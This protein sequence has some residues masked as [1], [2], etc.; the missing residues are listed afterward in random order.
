MNN[1]QLLHGKRA[2]VFGAGGS[3]G[4]AVAR[5]FAAEGAEV[6]LCGRHSKGLEDVM[7]SITDAGG[8]ARTVVVDAL[9]EVAVQKCV[10]EI[11]RTAGSIDIEFNAVAPRVEEYGGGKPAVDVTVGE[12]MVAVTTMLK[13]PIITALAA[14]RHI[15]KQRSGV[16]IGVTG[17]TARGHIVGG[18]AI[19]AAFG[20]LETFMENLAFEIG[21]QGVRALC[22][23]VTANVDSNAIHNVARAMNVTDGQIATML[24][25][26]NFLKTPMKLED[27]AKA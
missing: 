6:Y 4:S 19:G 20:A 3:V 9:D 14:A 2:L 24:A 23:R 10:D 16:I 22:L 7:R 25:N 15:T 17:S 26:Q 1:S 8:T 11:A 18:A 5:E 13:S 21:P 12:Y 27:T